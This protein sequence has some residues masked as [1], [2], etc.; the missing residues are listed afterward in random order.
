MSNSPPLPVLRWIDLTHDRSTATLMSQFTAF[1]DSR[2]LQAH[3]LADRKPG[4]RIDMICMHFDRPDAPGLNQLQQVK[5]VA[6][7]IPISMF[8]VQHSEE[9]AVWAMRSRVWEYITLPLSSA[10]LQR[11]RQALHGLLELRQSSERGARRILS[12]H[13]PDL[14]PSIRLTADH[15]KH[16]L[17]A[18]A[19][20]YIDLH[21]R[22][23]L[24]QKEL[25]RLCDMTPSRFSRLFRDVHGV[26]YLEYTLGK[27]LEFAKDRL[28]NSQMPITTI[29]YEAGF[30]DPSYFARAFKQ[31]V[32]CTPSEYRLAGGANAA[33]HATQALQDAAATPARLELDIG[34]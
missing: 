28:E 32:G 14:P 23:N 24:D 5:R 15:Q 29:G 16:Q 26:C 19:I 3:S 34:A 17:L 18:R 25:A 33:T 12:E 30:R 20:Q 8:T 21:F 22:E 31:F 11:F 1:S 2:L 7:S 27:R 9:L 4:Q 13:Y 6:P 10:E